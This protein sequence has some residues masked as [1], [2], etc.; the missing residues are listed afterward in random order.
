MQELLRLRDA[1][2]LTEY[3]AQWFRE[4]KDEEELFDTQNDPH[5][6]HNLANDPQYADKLKEL[7]AECDRWMEEID[8]RGLVNE[9][10]LIAQMWPGGRTTNQR[11][12]HKIERQ[13]GNQL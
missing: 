6:L 8:D 12:L 13:L 7:R 2:K 10:E 4:T 1:G 5:E 3:Q 11:L 9:A